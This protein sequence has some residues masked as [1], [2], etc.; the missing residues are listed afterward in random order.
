MWFIMKTVTEGITEF[1]WSVARWKILHPG[2]LF[3]VD[4][5]LVLGSFLSSLL[6][7]LVRELGVVVGVVDLA[8][9]DEFEE[10]GFV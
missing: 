5:E 7:L 1:I 8:G 10:L 6:Y 9:E 2:V 4:F 3:L